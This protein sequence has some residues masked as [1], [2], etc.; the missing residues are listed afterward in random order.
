[1]NRQNR[2]LHFLLISSAALLCFAWQT[3]SVS[4]A[5]PEGASADTSRVT[6]EI[7]R[8][9]ARLLHDV[10]SSTLHVMHERYFH[11]ERAIVPARAL[12]DVFADLARQSKVKARWISVNTKP[13]SVS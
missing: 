9:R 10:Y 11:D 13:M 7:A 4:S 1:M 3:I 2:L 8:D 5:E 6:V 12:E